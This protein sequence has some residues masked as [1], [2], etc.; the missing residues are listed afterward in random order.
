MWGATDKMAR[1]IAE[2]IA[3]A[4]GHPILMPLGPNHRSDIAT[5]VLGAG[6]LLVGSPT[7]NGG[8]FPSVADVLSYLGGLKP[9]NLV[10]AAFG[11][12]GW[13][14][15]AVGQVENLLKEMKVEM[16]GEAAKAKYTPDEDA[17]LNCRKLGQAIGSRLSEF[18]ART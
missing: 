3:E 12:Y 14:G 1:V 13:S 15:E 6:A 9:K 4:G 5:E 7:I 2:G 18:A 8:M 10:G 11:S 16:V 17:L